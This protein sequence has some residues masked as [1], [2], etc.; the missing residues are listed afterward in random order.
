[1]DS[2]ATGWEQRVFIFTFPNDPQAGGGGGA[3]T[4]ERRGRAARDQSS[5]PCSASDPAWGE[6][7]E[8]ARSSFVPASFSKYILAAA[9]TLKSMTEWL[10]EAGGGRWVSVKM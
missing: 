9:R 5:W 8:G 1:M 10:F 6:A 3:C 7:G 4:M 2:A